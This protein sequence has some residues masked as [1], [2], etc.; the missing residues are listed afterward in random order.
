MKKYIIASL[1]AV[2]F[3]A[4]VS[5]AQTSGADINALRAQVIVLLQRLLTLQAQMPAINFPNPTD[6]LAPTISSVTGPENLLPNVAGTWQVSAVDPDPPA[7]GGRL[8]YTAIW[9]DATTPS[10][11]TTTGATSFTHTY[12]TPGAYYLTFTAT[13]SGGKTTRAN[14]S[15]VVSSRSLPAPTVTGTAQINA[16]DATTGVTITTA[17]ITVLSLTGQ[18]IGTGNTYNG[19]VTFANLPVGIYTAT[20]VAIGYT[21]SNKTFNLLRAGETVPVNI[22]FTK[23]PVAPLTVTVRSAATNLPLDNV[24]VTVYGPNGL[25]FVIRQTNASGVAEFPNLTP[26]TTFQVGT[27]LLGYTRPARTSVTIPTTAS[28]TSISVNL[29]PAR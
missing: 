6:N 8:A 20:G 5:F 2:L 1:I 27:Y 19:P 15:V 29:Q 9:G 14:K 25:P 28:P 13:D 18:V 26:G 16:V 24:A 21:P 12:T 22:S 17:Q 3:I 23:I 4:N 10:W 7:G 11:S